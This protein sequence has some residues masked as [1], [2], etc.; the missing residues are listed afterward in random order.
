MEAFFAL[1]LGNLSLFAVSEEDVHT[2]CV[3]Y[4]EHISFIASG[5]RNYNV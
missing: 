4:K 3:Q 2:V 1:R 5:E